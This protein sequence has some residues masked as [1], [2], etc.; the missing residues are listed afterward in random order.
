MES[1]ASLV[2]CCALRWSRYGPTMVYGFG[3][4]L[5]LSRMIL[6]TLSWGN[7]VIWYA[8]VLQDVSIHSMFLQERANA[9]CQ[10]QAV[11]RK[12]IHSHACHIFNSLNPKTSH[13]L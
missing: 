6:R 7:T 11:L 12:P 4:G 3:Y 9:T 5:G 2:D 13:E 1:E 10:A 8:K